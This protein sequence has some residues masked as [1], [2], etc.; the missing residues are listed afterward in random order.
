MDK[1]VSAARLFKILTTNGYESGSHVDIYDKVNGLDDV[2][3]K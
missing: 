1:E 2:L 3:P